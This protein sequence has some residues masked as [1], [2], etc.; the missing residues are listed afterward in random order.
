MSGGKETSFTTALLAGGC[1]GTSVD[2]ALFP[3]DTIKTRLQDPRGFAAAGGFKGVYNGLGSAAAGS[4]PGAALFF[5]T[6]ETTKNYLTRSVDEKYHSGC[7]MA[8]SSAGEIAACLV[9]VP[10]ENVKQKLQAGLFKTTGE[11]INHIL[12]TQGASGF[13]V[14]Y[15][16]TVAREIPFSFIQFPIYEGMKKRITKYQGYEVTTVQSSLCGSVAGGF[17]AAVTTPLDVVKTRLMLGK[18]AQGVAYKGAM[19]TIKRIHAEG[20][21]SRFLSGVGPRTMWISIGGCVFFGAYEGAKSAIGG[22]ID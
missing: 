6:Y 1:A 3:L 7:Y 21:P 13:Y 19:D 11:T 17:S 16:T 5:S 15:M 18:D 12:K 10:T 2:I 20:G 9:R 14:G 22:M 4:A 8:A